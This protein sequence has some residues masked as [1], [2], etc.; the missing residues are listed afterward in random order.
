MNEFLVFYQHPEYILA[1]SLLQLH[2]CVKKPLAITASHSPAI[3]L[4][5]TVFVSRLFT[6]NC[7]LDNEKAEI[8]AC[9]ILMGMNA[10]CLTSIP[11]HRKEV[12]VEKKKVI[13]ILELRIYPST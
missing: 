8:H 11:W 6:R 7:L 4:F 9:F 10:P 3:T 13:L 5:V 12:I 1:V 2:C